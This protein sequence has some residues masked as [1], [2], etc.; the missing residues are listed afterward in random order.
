MAS[1]LEAD[2]KGFAVCVE[3]APTRLT[4]EW[5]A[6]LTRPSDWQPILPAILQQADG[7]VILEGDGFR[8]QIS[9]DRRQGTVRQP[10]ER[11]PI[12]A[13]VR[14]LLADSLL[15]RGGLLIHGVA[16]AHHGQAAL[17]TGFSGAGKSTLAQWGVQGGLSLLADELVAVLPDGDR[18]VVH[19]T[20]WNQGR[21]E[22]ATLAQIGILSHASQARL[23]P[24]EPAAVLRVLLSNLL[25]PA[26]T[27]DVRAR[28]F[29]I[30]SRLLS[31][32][33]TRRLA[34]APGCR[35]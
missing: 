11:F 19:G 18:F 26:E 2:W 21:P 17:F 9:A 25:E 4:L 29:R 6:P 35:L 7:S 31:Q 27:V 1:L 32:V 30:A 33:P 20:P 28:L 8:A 24:V 34:F 22:C 23:S 15:R 5:T 3:P 13:V 10:P 16:L 14:V 12:E